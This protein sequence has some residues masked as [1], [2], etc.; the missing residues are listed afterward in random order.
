MNILINIF[1]VLLIAFSSLFALGWLAYGI[2][3]VWLVFLGLGGRVAVRHAI[4]DP[5]LLS[6]RKFLGR[7]WWGGF[8]TGILLVVLALIQGS[9]HL[10]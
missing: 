5:K 8:L 3:I 9:L 7:V 6:L 1:S 2:V 4:Q 10:R